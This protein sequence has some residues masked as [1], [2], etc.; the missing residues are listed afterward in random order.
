[1]LKLGKFGDPNGI[2]AFSHLHNRAS[3]ERLAFNLGDP[4]EPCNGGGPG[5]NCPFFA[6]TCPER[7]RIQ[8]LP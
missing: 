6:A 7:F 4:G 1:M 3:E 8:S 5:L 2:H